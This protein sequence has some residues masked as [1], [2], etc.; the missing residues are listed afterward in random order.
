MAKRD[1][2]EYFSHDYASRVDDKVKPL[3]RKHKMLG[4]GIF[5][6]LVEDLYNNA[7]SVKLDYEGIADDLKCDVE[8]LKSVI[9]DFDLFKIKGD[10]FYSDSIKRRLK[11]RKEKSKKAKKSADKRWKKVSDDAN[12]LPTQS[13]GNAKK[14]TKEKETKEKETKENLTLCEF[15]DFFG[16][17]QKPRGEKKC[18]QLWEK[19]PDELRQE[20]I[21]HSIQY[22]DSTPDVQYR[23]DPLNYLLGEH[24]KD[25]I[26]PKSKP[27]VKSVPKKAITG[28]P[29]PQLSTEDILRLERERSERIQRDIEKRSGAKEP[30]SAADLTKS[31]LPP[32]NPVSENVPK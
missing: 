17:Y 30:H 32:A 8:T 3:I 21:T 4:Y 1:E 9:N 16:I 22:V 13:E 27:G 6:A 18:R 2:K 15:D 25:A 29:A 31:F 23:L 19:Y 14:E 5:W 24:W 11:L 10:F 12:A 26:I 20:I 28:K 7:N